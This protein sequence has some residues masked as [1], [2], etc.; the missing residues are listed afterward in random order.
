M[1]PYQVLKA[2]REI[3]VPLLL[4]LREQSEHKAHKVGKEVRV[5]KAVV[6]REHK[7]IKVLREHLLLAQMERKAN[8]VLKEIKELL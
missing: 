7:G 8:K 2:Y 6:L 1:Y 5:F 3:R 4:D